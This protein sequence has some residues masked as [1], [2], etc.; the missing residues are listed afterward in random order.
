MNFLSMKQP[1]KGTALVSEITSTHPV[2]FISYRV[3]NLQGIGNREEQEDSFAFVNAL[4]VREIKQNGLFAILADGMGGMS[5]GSF[6]SQ[7]AIQL[8]TEDF[9]QMNRESDISAQLW[10]SA[11]RAGDV[12]FQKLNGSGGSTVVACVFYQEKFSYI[13]IG[14]SCLY[15][16]RDS[17]IIQ[18]NRP[19]DVR[20]LHY[21][22]SIRSGDLN[23]SMAEEDVEREAI[24]DFLGMPVLIEADRFLRPLPLRDRDVFLICSDGVGDVLTTEE[25]AICMSCETPEEIS[26]S[27]EEHI[28]SKRLEHQDNY[29]ALIVQCRK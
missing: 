16:L 29:T 23:P 3:A 20:N 26:R 7:T 1:F 28:L 19:H 15:L 21:L 14:D 13:S 11:V 9:R 22:E 5:G 27:L 8:M 6:A 4:D 17:E 10:D 24:V 18:I 2:R 12:I 25:L